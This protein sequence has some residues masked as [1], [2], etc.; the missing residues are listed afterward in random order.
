MNAQIDA[1]KTYEEDQD[2][3]QRSHYPFYCRIIDKAKGQ[4]YAEPID[5]DSGKDVTARKTGAKDE[6]LRFW[7]R[8][9]KNNLE[10]IE[11]SLSN[12]DGKKKSQ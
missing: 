11:H 4:V 6:H 1:T 8:S 10:D 7:P 5:H 3:K 12:G 9:L 2:E